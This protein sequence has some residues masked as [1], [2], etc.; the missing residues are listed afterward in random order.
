MFTNINILNDVYYLHEYVSLYIN[1]KS[2][3][4]E[5]K[6]EH[7]EKKF[8]TIAIK[9]PIE[10]IGKI[11]CD[12]QYYDLETAYGYG[13]FYTNTD[14]TLFLKEA[15]HLYEKKC[16]KENII[17][18][19][20]RFHPFNNFPIMYKNFLDF[21]LYDRDIVIKTIKNN[22]IDSYKS[23]VRNIIKNAN[24]K[25]VIQESLDLDNFIVLYNKTMKKNN[26][27]K[28][29]FFTKEYYKNLL[30]NNFAKLYEVIY[31]NEIIAMGFFMFGKD[32]VHYHLSAN[33]EISY[34]L[35]AN[36]ALLDH[37]F[38]KT[39]SL[40]KNICLLG[41]G[42]TSSK[43]DS[44]FKFKKKFSNEIKP[45]Y[46]GGKI[47]NKEIYNKYIKLWEEQSSRDINYFLKY[48]LDI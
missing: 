45:F 26:A 4:F 18:E 10:Y 11:K 41:G 22:V 6:Y 31:Q 24:K 29:Y 33:S 23:K 44:L 35:N 37:V 25:L 40:N 3:L 46:I 2:K 36:Y 43:E 9:K 47:Y 21:T 16:K 19:F 27:D 48:R 5:F 8:Y 13:G 28:F 15:M 38:N 17:A 39:N 14:D 34:S 7:N 20:I 12:K 1:D 42:T 32:I 30:N